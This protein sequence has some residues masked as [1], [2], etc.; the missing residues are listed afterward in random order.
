MVGRVPVGVGHAL[1]AA[2][3]AFFPYMFA[4]HQPCVFLFLFLPSICLTTR[5][6][7]GG[8]TNDCVAHD[9]GLCVE[10]PAGARAAQKKIQPPPVAP[11]SHLFKLRP[12][13]RS[14]R[15]RLRQHQRALSGLL[16]RHPPALLH[17]RGIRPPWPTVVTWFGTVPD[18]PL[19]IPPTLKACPPSWSAHPQWSFPP[20]PTPFPPPPPPPPVGTHSS[21][22]ARH[23]RCAPQPAARVRRTDRLPRRLPSRRGR[24]VGGGGSSSTGSEAATPWRGGHPHGGVSDDGACCAVP[25]HPAGHRAGSGG[26]CPPGGPCPGARAH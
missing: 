16:C 8:P 13:V 10:R 21:V 14:G 26:G 6:G 9:G 24:K 2:L 22:P 4:Q 11:R 18:R 15:R 25:A 12:A 17:R 1:A 23:A 20:P 7:E 5:L 3:I 19:P